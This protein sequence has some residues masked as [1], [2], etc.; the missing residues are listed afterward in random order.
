MQGFGETGE[1][2]NWASS[3][4]QEHKLGPAIFGKVP[5]GS[6]AAVKYNAAWL[7]GMTDA[8]PDNTFRMQVEYEF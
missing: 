6:H 1:W 8:T 7:V 5:V 2:D 4:E 3:D